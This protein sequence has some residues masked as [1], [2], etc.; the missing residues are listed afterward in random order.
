M[1][2]RVLS[3]AGAQFFSRNQ[4]DSLTVRSRQRKV[5]RIKRQVVNHFSLPCYLTMAVFQISLLKNIPECEGK[6]MKKLQFCLVILSV[7]VLATGA[8]AQIQNGQFTG[9]VTDPSG[10]AVP[11][12][13][14]TV[15]NLGTNLTVTTTTNNSGL[16]TAKELPVR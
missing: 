2:R 1:C 15:T 16:Y 7:L 8:V 3:R 11:N 6:S 5:L 9:I 4:Q 14:V 10:A 13:K 12:A